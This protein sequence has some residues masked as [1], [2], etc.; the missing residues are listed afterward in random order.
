MHPET[1]RQRLARVE[2]PGRAC[3]F[4][5]RHRHDE[6]SIPPHS[7]STRGSCNLR[8]ADRGGFLPVLHPGLDE[9]PPRLYVPCWAETAQRLFSAVVC[10]L[11][12]SPA[13]VCHKSVN[14][15]SAPCS[16]ISRAKL[17]RPC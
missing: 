2:W 11:V 15:V 12:Q 7:P 3:F 5:V 1:V 16:S 9:F 8:L 13:S 10:G 17:T 6:I 14:P 4:S